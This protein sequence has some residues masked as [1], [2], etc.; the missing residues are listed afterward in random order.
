M[1]D[2]LLDLLIA[3]LVLLA[4][5]GTGRALRPLLPFDF[6]SRSA[7]LAY[8]LGLGLAVM[9]TTLFIVSL[10]D[11]LI[12]LVGWILLII[13]L[14]LAGWQYRQLIADATAFWQAVKQGIGA[15]W[16]VKIALLLGVIFALV[17]LIADLAP[18][19]EGDTVHQYLLLP[20]YWVDAGRYFQPTHIWAATLPGNMMMLSAWAL[21]L[22][23]SFSLATL[24]TGFGM[25]LFFALGVYAL[26]RAYFG[27]G[28]AA[29]AAVAITT[30]P[31]AAYLAQSAKVDMGWAFFEVLTLA[32]FFKW[33][34][35]TQV[36]ISRGARPCAPTRGFISDE[37]RLQDRVAHPDRWLILAG[38]CLGLAAGSKNQ[39]LISV[40]LLGS[41]LILHQAIRGDWRGLIRASLA[42]GGAIII[43]ALPYYLYN[44][45]VHS[46][47][48]YPVFAD[49]FVNW[50]G[51]TPSPRSELGTEVFYPWTV[52]GYFRNLWGMSFGHHPD[53]NF[54]LGFITGP[55]FLLTIPVGLVLGL[56]RGERIARRMLLYALIFSVIWFLV[57]QA[58]RHFL[59]GLT[60]LAV[61]SGL[62]LWKLA[63][64]RYWANRLTFVMVLLVIIW[65]Q[66]N[67]LGV[68]YWNGAPRVALGLETR[69]AYIQRI[70]DRVWKDTF[71]DW[72]TIT[73]LNEQL[74]PSDRILTEHATSPLYIEPQL[75]PDSWGDRERLDTVDDPET[76]LNKL[77]ANNINY[78]LVYKAS[79]GSRLYTQSE[80]LSE[81][82]VL[83][84]DGPRTQLYE[85]KTR[86]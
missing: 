2:L 47:P 63:A 60:L 36:S 7:D 28:A 38:A 40:A 6:W 24:I 19:V 80:F 18:P 53:L 27:R 30:M 83:I 33:L 34:D 14:A 46:N 43:A 52:S 21:L 69:Q 54:Y 86:D 62:V 42:F 57:K 64:K 55:V 72:E 78:I 82:A 74:G 79:M 44:G 81:Y 39:A 35:L 51:A 56:L 29:L 66:I 9:T 11:L 67:I 4:I 31:D 61:V 58:A 12:P 20:R 8:A 23:D 13:G 45:I 85:L 16:L 77:A 50:F 17:N 70:H 68:L 1:I 32:A 15:S 3:G 73:T 41:W 22:R 25:S 65:N 48:F 59:P 10:I 5:Y 49:Q 26:A 37:G 71:P 76:L 84:Y 75:V